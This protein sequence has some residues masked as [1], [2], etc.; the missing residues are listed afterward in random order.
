MGEEYAAWTKTGLKSVDS[1]AQFVSWVNNPVAKSLR[2]SALVWLNDAAV[3]LTGDRHYAQKLRD[4]LG[5][6]LL[7]CWHENHE[8]MRSDAAVWSAFHTLLQRLAD[9]QHPVALEVQQL[10]AQHSVSIG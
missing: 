6:L 1:A 9:T 2:L 3:K 4:S 8:Q 7:R 5:K 10:I